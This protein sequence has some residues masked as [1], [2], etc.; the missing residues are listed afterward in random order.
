VQFAALTIRGLPLDR[1]NIRGFGE[2]RSRV[3]SSTH[4]RAGLMASGLFVHKISAR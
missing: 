3:S 4:G 1:L 2:S